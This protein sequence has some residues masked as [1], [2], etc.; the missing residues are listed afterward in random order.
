VRD[1]GDALCPCDLGDVRVC[2]F[3]RACARV[4]VCVTWVMSVCVCVPRCTACS[5]ASLFWWLG[6]CLCMLTYETVTLGLY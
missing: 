6:R 2:A 5:L 1:L 3:V 4:C